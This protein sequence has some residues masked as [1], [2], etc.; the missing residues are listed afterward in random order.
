MQKSEA[1]GVITSQIPEQIQIG[2]GKTGKAHWYAMRG[3]SLGEFN[4]VKCFF[5]FHITPHQHAT[6]T[7][8]QSWG[9]LCVL[10]LAG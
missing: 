3:G 6:D 8:H 1:M 10:Y 9:S 7:T 5:Y 4:H 2:W